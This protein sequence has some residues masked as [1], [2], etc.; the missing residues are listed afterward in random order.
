[1]VPLKNRK[2]A[3]IGGTAGIGLA[4]A[5]LLSDR[6][7]EVTVGGREDGH[8]AEAREAIGNGVAAI[9]VDA[10]DPDSLE[11][12]FDQAGPIDDLVI[13]VTR[14]G[15]AGPAADLADQDLEDA[16]AGKPA[17]HL[18]A[19]AEALPKLNERGSVTLVSAGSAQSALPQTALLAAVNG[20]VEAAV[21]P[22]ARELAPRRVNAVSP[23]VIDTGWWDFL[24]E[25]ERKATFEQLSEQAPVGR[26]G[27]ADD[28][29]HAICEL[30]E[31]DYING[32]VLPCDGGLRP[33]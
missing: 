14:R 18:R 13:T 15:G 19:V 10:T 5:R 30:I 2:A 4:T 22:L 20:A 11:R 27:S 1:M 33:T 29:A 6:R 9:P 16:F 24:P 25:Q 7:A 17:A 32:V 21:P 26:I 12:F 8:L 23:G 31:N 28:V 3:I